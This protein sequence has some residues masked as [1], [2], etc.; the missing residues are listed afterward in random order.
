M[1]KL[2]VLAVVALLFFGVAS[3]S[4][5]EE[6]AAGGHPVGAEPQQSLPQKMRRPKPMKNPRRG[7]KGKTPTP[8]P[9]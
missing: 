3:V 8:A 4:W 1:K 7:S 2:M 6:G 9:Q 5:A